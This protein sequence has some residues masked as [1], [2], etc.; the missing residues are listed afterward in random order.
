[1]PPNSPYTGVLVLD[2]ING[3]AYVDISERADIALAEKWTA[4]LGYKD[5]VTFRYCRT[6]KTFG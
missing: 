3:V 4:E 6:K 5:L 2:R 1:V